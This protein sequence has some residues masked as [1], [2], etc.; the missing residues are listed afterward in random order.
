MAY[1]ISGR[2]M[3]VGHTQTLTSKSG[4]SYTK[5]D[6]VMT[7]RK[8]DPYTGYPSEDNDN[9][10]K[11]TFMGQQCQQ[12]DTIKTGDIVVVHFDIS[13]RSYE[14]DGRTEYFTEVRPFRVE[15]PNGQ[16]NQAA[17]Q[18]YNTGSQPPL[19][20]PIQPPQAY[21]QTSQQTTSPFGEQAFPAAPGNLQS[22]DDDLPF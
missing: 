6:L 7:V 3:I 10:P 18:Q 22:K 17:P 5:R 8:F 15:Q 12:L 14:K 11:F 13:G 1:K 20:D 2:V 4:N 21:Q 19:Q 16:G 9:T